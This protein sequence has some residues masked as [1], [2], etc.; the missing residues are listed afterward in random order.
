[1]IQIQ[2]LKVLHH[3]MLSKGP[4]FCL[5][6]FNNCKS[7]CIIFHW[8]S[9]FWDKATFFLR[10]LIRN[11]F[12]AQAMNFIAISS[13]ELSDHFIKFLPHDQLQEQFRRFVLCLCMYFCHLIV[14]WPPEVKQEKRIPWNEQRWISLSSWET[15]YF[16]QHSFLFL[17]IHPIPV[18]LSK[19]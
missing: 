6:I 3:F 8:V 12:Q 19:K 9:Q 5:F 15:V 14:L 7:I 13:Q 1:M 16:E 11:F 10:H 2:I 17:F 4:S 18:V